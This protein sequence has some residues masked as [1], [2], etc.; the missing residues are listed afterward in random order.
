MVTVSACLMAGGFFKLEETV[1]YEY[2][3]VFPF[4]LI[5]SLYLFLVGPV[6]ILIGSRD[7]LKRK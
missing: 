6:I 5:V 2:P 3:F 7:E 1:F 4:L